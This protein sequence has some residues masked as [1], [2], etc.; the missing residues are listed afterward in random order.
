MLSL[1]NRASIDHILL[2]EASSTAPPLSTSSSIIKTKAPLSYPTNL[3]TEPSLGSAEPKL[4]S[5][6][7]SSV[8]S[9]ETLFNN[10]RL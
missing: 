5:G 2:F 10:P 1:A 7:L 6:P 9:S 4:E 8:G 3:S